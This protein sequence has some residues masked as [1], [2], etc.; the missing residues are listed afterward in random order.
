ML[1]RLE[2]I[3]V[4]S[5]AEFASYEGDMIFVDTTC[6][7]SSQPIAQAYLSIG[8]T[9]LELPE[10]WQESSVFG[11]EVLMTYE[12]GVIHTFIGLEVAE[13]L[14]P[15]QH[16]FIKVIAIGEVAS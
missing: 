1:T 9:E 11:G 7:F 13:Q 16:L 6:P 15:H 3:T 5:A 14:E 4:I 2:D 10:S 8:D 12:D